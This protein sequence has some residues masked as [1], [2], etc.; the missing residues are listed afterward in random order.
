MT[1]L[2]RTEPGRNKNQERRL[3]SLSATLGRWNVSLHRS[4]YDMLANNLQQAVN[5]QSAAERRRT[6]S[7]GY[8]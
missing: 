4:K 1:A 8:R 3:F 7:N 6:W 5:A 2:C